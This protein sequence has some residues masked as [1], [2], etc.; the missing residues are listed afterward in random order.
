MNPH[1]GMDKSTEAQKW[2]KPSQS[3]GKRGV[4]N[5]AQEN[6]D[7]MYLDGPRWNVA[8]QRSIES[9]H[10]FFFLESASELLKGVACRLVSERPAAR[11]L[12][13]DHDH[14]TMPIV[15]QTDWAWCG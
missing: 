15:L 13:R 12:P 2:T 3:L 1:V 7:S 4:W 11:A 9:C 8:K 14:G 5:L 6:Y 10:I